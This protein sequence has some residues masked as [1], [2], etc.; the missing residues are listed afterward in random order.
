MTLEI[1]FWGE[2]CLPFSGVPTL[3]AEIFTTPP[4]INQDLEKLALSSF[5]HPSALCSRKNSSCLLFFLWKGSEK[6]E[7][8]LSV[9]FQI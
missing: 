3:E 4:T 6:K 8:M 1:A 9:A 2:F 7:N 5:F